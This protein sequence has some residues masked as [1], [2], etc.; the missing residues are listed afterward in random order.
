MWKPPIKNIER[1]NT[2]YIFMWL[3]EYLVKNIFLVSK[4]YT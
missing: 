3:E 1:T 2:N 4:N